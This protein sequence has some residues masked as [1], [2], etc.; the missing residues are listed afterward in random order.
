MNNFGLGLVLSFTDNLSSNVDGAILSINGLV[1]SLERVDDTASTISL[2]SLCAVAN[3]V[4]DTFESVGEDILGVFSSIFDNVMKTGSQFENYKVTLNALYGDAQR[5]SEELDKMFSFA[6]TSPVDME[7]VMPYVIKLKTLGLEAFEE[8]SNLQGQSQDAIKWVTDFMSVASG[9]GAST[10]RIGRAITNFLNPDNVQS[11]RIMN[12]IFGDVKG[13]IESVG[14][15]LGNTVEDRLRNL[16]SLV[17]SYGANGITESL[18][19]NWSTLLSNMEDVWMQFWLGIADGGAFDSVKFSLQEIVKALN[20]VDTTAFGQVIADG[21]KVITV[22]LQNLAH[23]ISVAITRFTDFAIAHPVL[24]KIA[25]GAFAVTGALSLLSGVVLKIGSQIGMMAIGLKVFGDVMSGLRTSEIASR[26]TSLGGKIGWLAVSLTSLYVLWNK[27]F[28]GIKTRTISFVNNVNS[29]F[30]KARSIITSNSADMKT[31][32]DALDDNNPFDN[33]TRG[34]VR[35]GV[36]IGVVKEGIENNDGNGNFLIS[37]DSYNSVVELGLENLVGRIFDAVYAVQ[38]FVQGFKNGF[39]QI[40]QAVSG[41]ISGLKVGI[42]GTFLD[43]LLTKL[44]DFAKNLNFDRDSVFSFFETLGQYAGKIAPVVLAL[45]SA[46][47]V[48]SGLGK[49]AGGI[50]GSLSGLFG[51]FSGID[52][53]ALS[54]FFGNMSS[55]LSQGIGG[56]LPSIGGALSTLLMG[57]LK[58]FNP[59]NWVAGI[60]SIFFMTLGKVENTLVH[61][62][63]NTASLIKVLLGGDSLFNGA[64]EGLYNFLDNFDEITAITKGKFGEWFDFFYS[65]ISKPFGLLSKLITGPFKLVGK[66]FS[67]LANPLGAVLAVITGIGSAFVGAYTHFDGFREKIN[68][69]LGL[70]E[71]LDFSH[72]FDGITE[73]LGNAW[74]ILKESLGDIFSFDWLKNGLNFGGDG[75][76]FGSAFDSIKEKVLGMWE[77]ISPVLARFGVVFGYIAGMVW[78]VVGIIGQA[79]AVATKAIAPFLQ[80]VVSGIMI[81]INGFIGVATNIIKVAVGFFDVIRGLFQLVIGFFTGNSDLMSQAWQTIWDGVSSVWEGIKGLFSTIWTFL[82]DWVLNIVDTGKNMVLGIWDG[83][84][85]AWSTL[86]EGVKN[87]FNNL[88]GAVKNLLGIHSPSTIFSDIGMFLIQGL[89]NGVQAMIEFVVGIF[90]TLWDAIKAVFDGV[91]TF[92]SEIGSSVAE[93]FTSGFQLA[94]DMVIGIFGTFIDFFKGIWDSIVGLFTGE[95]SPSEFFSSVFQKAYDLVTGIFSTLGEFFGGIWNKIV[96]LFTD[97]GSTVGD[98]VSNIISTAVNAILKTAVG[99]INGFISAINFA[100]GIINAIPGVSITKLSKLEV[101]EMATGGVVDKA[102]LAVVGEAGKEAVMP[103]ENNT[104]WINELAGSIA[105]YNT[106]S[107]NA[108]IGGLVTPVLQSDVVSYVR[109]I[110]QTLTSILTLMNGITNY[111]SDLNTTSARA[112]G[113]PVI[114]NTDSGND[115]GNANTHLV[116]VVGNGGGGVNTYNTRNYNTGD[117]LTKSSTVTKERNVDNSVVFQSGAI[118]IH[119]SGVSEAEAE[120][121]A[122]LIMRKIERARQIKNMNNYRAITE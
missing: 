110:G 70:K 28:G 5:A 72:I 35:L 55:V 9:M 111:S 7:N 88:V 79:L 26:L 66:L 118:V 86:V 106:S 77:V 62:V 96:E 52:G 76:T 24:T 4:G 60:A 10:D 27:D 94:Y 25:I 87:F 80:G 39:N 91:V 48:L 93:F 75:N 92:F 108:N 58:L 34:L 117:Y 103:L 100:I 120:R 122:Q 95:L 99:I 29:S 82:C 50:T 115:S 41:F 43:T 20:G 18:M 85:N 36:L 1:S 102:T 69:L 121:F 112:D 40:S 97:I 33:L 57:A 22:P 3:Q 45:L 56:M 83:I 23:W 19:G 12:N 46:K 47:T 98:T 61:G 32:L 2:M 63:V 65:G 51:V 15:T 84:T 49:I 64:H 105:K 30:S 113:L 71:D 14:D 13:K 78:D 6:V 74:E 53:G 44:D 21:L 11:L 107:T 42:K 8:V 67:F 109:V 37:M 17:T 114:I 119:T 89:I 54:G 101:P 90:T 116:P 68:S 38:R 104:G 59:A 81:F 16:A 31:A 73:G